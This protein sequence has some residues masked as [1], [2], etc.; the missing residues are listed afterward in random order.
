MVRVW[1]GDIE[2]EDHHGIETREVVPMWPPE[3]QGQRVVRGSQNSKWFY[4]HPDSISS[5]IPISLMGL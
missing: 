5:S 3:S 1:V 4:F 2:C